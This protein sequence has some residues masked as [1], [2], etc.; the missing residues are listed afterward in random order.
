[1]E[2]CCSRATIGRSARSR[3]CPRH[4]QQRP[5]QPGAELR[6]RLATLDEASLTGALGELLGKR[7]LTAMLQRRDAVLASAAAAT[8]GSAMSR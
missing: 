6:R 4:L 3:D 2:R 8:A 5:P 1:M 7:E